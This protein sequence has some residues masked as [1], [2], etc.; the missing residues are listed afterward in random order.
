MLKPDKE[1]R[2]ERR[3]K[4]KRAKRQNKAKSLSTKTAP[5]TEPQE[6]WWV[7]K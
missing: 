2:K 3:K 1:R 4:D 6:T 5:L 7:G